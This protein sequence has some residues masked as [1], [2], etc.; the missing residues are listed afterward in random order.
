MKAPRRDPLLISVLLWLVAS[1]M[2]TRLPSQQVSPSPLR[3]P[4]RIEVV[5]RDTGRGVPLVQLETTGAIRYVTDSAGVVAFDEPGLLGTR[6]WFGVSSHGYTHPEDRFGH[7]GVTLHTKPGGSARVAIDRVNIAERLYRVTGQGIYRDTILTGGKAPISQPLLNARVAGQDSVLAI[8][9]RGRILWFWGDTHRPRYALGLFK[10]AGAW[11]KLPGKGALPP[12]VGVDLNYFTNADG[13]ARA[14]CPIEGPGVVWISGVTLIEDTLVCHYSR[15]KGLETPLES[16]IARWNPTSERFEKWKQLPLTETRHI[17]HHP[18][19][20]VMDGEK[21]IVVGSPF[22]ELRVRATLADVHDPTRFERW[23][24]DGWRPTQGP[25]P[26]PQQVITSKDGKLRISA[27]PGSIR[28]NAHRKKWI[29]IFGEAFGG[30]SIL[31]EVWYAESDAIT[32]PWR[33]P[34]KIVTHDRYS[35]YNVTHHD[36]MDD[37]RYLYFEGTYTT[38][39]SKTKLRTPRYDYNQIMYRLDLD[40]PRLR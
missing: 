30:P 35:F 40:D 37:G 31:G 36:F 26:S 38:L 7:R 11:S 32:G 2:W 6:I 23:D 34:R 8:P 13:F 25:T 33:D 15:R 22:P 19:P 3:S 5:D 1:S 39:F 20:V 28:W 9:Y 12:R 14:M 10:T 27:R 21:W 24:G 16:G 29:A 4:F 18:T 17:K